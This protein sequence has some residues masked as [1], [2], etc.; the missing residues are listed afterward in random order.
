M[1]KRIHVTYYSGRKKNK[2]KKSILSGLRNKTYKTILS[3]LTLD[4]AHRNS[5]RKMICEAHSSSLPAASKGNREQ[6]Y[7]PKNCSS[8]KAI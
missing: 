6:I 1:N 4:I 7:L 2:I 8:L 5:S 3:R